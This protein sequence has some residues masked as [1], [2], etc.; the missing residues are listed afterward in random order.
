MAISVLM[1]PENSGK[2][3]AFLKSLEDANDAR[4]RVVLVPDQFKVETERLLCERYDNLLLFTKVMSLSGLA[5]RLLKGVDV[6]PITGVGETLVVTD[7]LQDNPALRYFR[8]TTRPN[9]LR[10]LVN[11]INQMDGPLVLREDVL[12][13]ESVEELLEVKN[14]FLLKV[15]D[16][17]HIY[18][19]YLA[20]LC[21]KYTDDARM[22]GLA[23][24]FVESSTIVK[25]AYFFVDHYDAL[26]DNEAKLLSA[27]GEHAKGVVVS[28]NA[29]ENEVYA[30]PRRMLAKL[31]SKA[32]IVAFSPKQ[33]NTVFHRLSQCIL[34]SG[35]ER[36]ERQLRMSEL[37]GHVAVYSAEDMQQEADFVASEVYRLIQNGVSPSRI[38]VLSTDLG[39][40]RATLDVTLRKYGIPFFMESR[41]SVSNNPL[42][43]FIDGFLEVVQARTEQRSDLEGLRNMLLSG[44]FPLADDDAMA[45]Y[46]K[47]Q[48]RGST[49]TRDP[50]FE[51]AEQVLSQLVEMGFKLSKKQSFA[52][53]LRSLV[54]ALLHETSEGLSVRLKCELHSLRG[55]GDEKSY[56]ARLWNRFVDAVEELNVLASEVSNKKLKQLRDLIATA[57]RQIS[58]PVLPIH[59]EYVVVA[60][61]D[62]ARTH[63][64]S[65]LFVMGSLRGKLPSVA[66]RNS[67]FNAREAELFDDSFRVVSDVEEEAYHLH[68]LLTRPTEQLVFTYPRDHSDGY[69]KIFDLIHEDRIAS[70]GRGR[71]FHE[72][73]DRHILHMV[74]SADGHG[75][76]LKAEDIA[77]R[78][79]FLHPSESSDVCRLSASGVEEFMKCPALYFVSRKIRPSVLEPAG[80]SAQSMGNIVHSV[81]EHF[82]RDGYYERYLDT[83]DG[84]RTLVLSELTTEAWNRVISQYQYQK[85]FTG[86]GISAVHEKNL[87]LDCE[88]AVQVAIRQVRAGILVPTRFEQSFSVKDDVRFGENVVFTGKIDRIDQVEYEGQKIYRIIDYKTGVVDLKRADYVKMVG[89]EN[90][91]LPSY[92]M[93]AELGGIEG[94]EPGSLCAGLYLLPASY[95]RNRKSLREIDFGVQAL[96]GLTNVSELAVKAQFGNLDSEEA[97]KGIVKNFGVAESELPELPVL[98]E[99]ASSTIRETAVHVREGVF[100]RIQSSKNCG[101]CAY[102]YVCGL[103]MS[104]DVEEDSFDG[105]E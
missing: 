11:L 23:A 91:Q 66:S 58:I 17:N 79:G 90:I 100:D 99:V 2:M 76:A 9:A 43:G 20:R 22:T 32:K 82:F 41:I 36:E 101:E 44:V 84:E 72:S 93:A 74:H 8:S 50:R 6:T 14:S 25:D 103:D 27:L 42:Y 70:E 7:I 59:K 68:M 38:A 69:S 86:K 55:E 51:T 1:G 88:R 63:E 49:F 94:I 54:Q 21:E 71:G 77:W 3:D 30:Y 60:P 40:Y 78:K 92:A 26:T 34:G 4:Y 85:Y 105:T 87:K 33:D 57:F 46:R 16:I 102:R 61:I 13:S 98:I 97:I 62:R 67:V 24:A 89:G 45:Y 75:D 28:L 18:E 37:E 95:Y 80:M 64:I 47:I 53:M 56:G 73:A 35:V 83:S 48:E 52:D 81:M 12:T 104:V 31:P 15:D 19:A 29:D 96:Q 10:G 39:S 5:E 65:H